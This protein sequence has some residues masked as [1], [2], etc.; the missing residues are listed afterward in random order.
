MKKEIVLLADL[1]CLGLGGLYFGEGEIYEGLG[2]LA[3]IPI[4]PAILT[5]SGRES[6]PILRMSWLRWTFTV[7]SAG[8]DLGGDLL[9]EKAG[10]YQWQHF[11]LPRGQPFKALPQRG[12]FVLLLAS[13]CVP[14]QGEVNRVQQILIAEWFGQELDGSGLHGPDRHWDVTVAGNKDNRNGNVGLGQLG[15]GNRA[16]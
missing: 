2:F 3:G 5:S 16:H 4:F 7:V 6:A 12:D 10:N 9:V 14:L 1:W 15:A 13:G 8:S 11:A